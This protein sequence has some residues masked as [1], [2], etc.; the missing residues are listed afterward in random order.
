MKLH[1]LAAL[2]FAFALLLP[3][4]DAGSVQAPPAEDQIV[5]QK[6]FKG[7]TPEFQEIVV[8][9]SGAAK[10]KEAPDDPN[11]VEFKVPAAVTDSLFQH[12]AALGY[13]QRKLESGLNIAKMGEKTLRYEGKGR[14]SQ[15]YNYSLEPDA[16]KL[17]ELFE[18]IGDSQRLFIKL[19][20]T[21]KFDRLGINDALVAMEDARSRERLIGTEHFLPLLDRIVK[22]KRFMNIARNR[23]DYL[24]RYIRETH[25]LNAQ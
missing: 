5:Y 19:E 12:A 24:A 13:F 20:Y 21:V 9:R 8:S 11:P 3:A 22:N 15:T 10:Y 6:V 23:A 16:Q 17:Q 4:Q 1:W 18:K 2:V 7:S 14:G 25:G